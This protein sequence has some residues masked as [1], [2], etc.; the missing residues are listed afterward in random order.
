[1]AFMFTA[2][3]KEEHSP[4]EMTN[5]ILL[6]FHVISPNATKYIS[7]LHKKILKSKTEAVSY[8]VAWYL[9]ESGRLLLFQTFRVGTYSKV[10]VYSN[11]YVF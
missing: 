7:K 11:K 8:I 6:N 2:A 5:L 3:L 9:F 10:G 4:A 1:M